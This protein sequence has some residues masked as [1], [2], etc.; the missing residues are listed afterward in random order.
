MQDQNELLYYLAW[1]SVIHHHM[2]QSR[3][4]RLYVTTLIFIQI[5][6]EEVGEKKAEVNF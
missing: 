4:H 3:I 5:D 2:N 1:R 6:N